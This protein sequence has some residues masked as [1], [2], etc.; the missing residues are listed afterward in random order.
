MP[1]L[2]VGY[3]SFHVH[4]HTSCS[5]RRSWQ[6]GTGNLQVEGRMSYSFTVSALSSI[7]WLDTPALLRFLGLPAD[8]RM[9]SYTPE[10]AQPF[11]RASLPDAVMQWWRAVQDAHI[12]QLRTAVE[13]DE[14]SK[15]EIVR[16]LYAGQDLELSNLLAYVEQAG[17]DALAAGFRARNRDKYGLDAELLKVAQARGFAV[18]FPQAMIAPDFYLPFT[19]NLILEV[20]DWR[21]E[22]S[23]FGSLPNLARELE[24][25]LTLIEATDPAATVA[26]RT[27]APHEDRLVGAYNAARIKLELVRAGLRENLPFWYSE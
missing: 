3:V 25:V 26:G 22:T 13:W 14:T 27:D 15:V 4:G 5:A 23:R 24:T 21:G 7:E 6:H 20:P 19:A 12:G 10:Q 11:Q 1:G 18:R 2:H 9:F 17:T 16:Y 8:T